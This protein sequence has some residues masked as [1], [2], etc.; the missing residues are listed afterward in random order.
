MRS[1]C[2]VGGEAAQPWDCIT[3][4][5]GMWFSG[6][7]SLPVLYTWESY[8]AG[9]QV[10]IVPLGPGRRSLNL[11]GCKWRWTLQTPRLAGWFWLQGTPVSSSP[12]IFKKER[13]KDRKKKKGGG[14][15]ACFFLCKGWAGSAVT[16][17]WQA[18]YSKDALRVYLSLLP[19]SEWSAEFLGA[20]ALG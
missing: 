17:V 15:E 20:E 14:G 16:T 1:Q 13:K 8:T 6:L 3:F 7:A 18:E 4:Y 9:R 11:Q 19:C 12:E 2:K 10:S 5:T